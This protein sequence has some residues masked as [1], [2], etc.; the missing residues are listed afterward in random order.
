M[1]V[2]HLIN[3]SSGAIDK[4]GITIDQSQ[5]YSDA[6]LRAEN[7]RYV[8]RAEYTWRYPAMVHENIELTFYRYQHGD[9]RD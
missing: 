5:R 6:Y 3:N 8:T 7:V 4:I 2:Y 9:S 1:E